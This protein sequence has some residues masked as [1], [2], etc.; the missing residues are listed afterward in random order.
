MT[1][2]VAAV[3]YGR[4]ARSKPFTEQDWSD[5]TNLE[6]SS[7]YERSKTIAERAAW[8]W[9][10]SAGGSMELV[11]ICPGAV[12]GL[13]WPNVAAHAHSVDLLVHEGQSEDARRVLVRAL[14][15]NGQ[16]G[17]A[18]VMNQ[19]AVYHATP[20][21]AVAVANEAKARLL[22]F[23]HMGPIDPN[24]VLTKAIFTRGLSKLRPTNAWKLGFDGMV[25]DLPAG[26]STI[27]SSSVE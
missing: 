5:A 3:A 27:E 25:V 12:L 9:I 10:R 24:N 7:P 26:K 15:Q 6:D 23:N 20:A 8:D 13:R 18:N 17:L 4:G 11:T 14:N 21:D 19:V 22:V 16:R 2:S 1:S